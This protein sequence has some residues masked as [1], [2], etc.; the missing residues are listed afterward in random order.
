LGKKPFSVVM[1][2][3]DRTAVRFNEFGSLAR[4]NDHS[5]SSCSR[6]A[7]A[8]TPFLVFPWKRPPLVA[9]KGVDPRAKRTAVRQDANRRRVDA[10]EPLCLSL[11]VML[12]T[13]A[14]MT[15]ESGRSV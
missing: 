15:I 1:A 7:R 14:S 10:D 11:I 5:R 9:G 3:L 13:S 4:W 2:W 6:L 12:A 8:S